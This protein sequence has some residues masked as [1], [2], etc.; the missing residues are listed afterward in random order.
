MVESKRVGRLAQITFS[1]LMHAGC[2]AG[3][4]G[5]SHSFHF[6]KAAA[7]HQCVFRCHWQHVSVSDLHSPRQQR[8]LLQAPQLAAGSHRGVQLPLHC[9]HHPEACQPASLGYTIGLKQIN[10]TSPSMV[11]G[12]CYIFSFVL[13]SKQRCSVKSMSA[14]ELL[15][16]C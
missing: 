15:E 8:L 13:A 3:F 10:F 6:G 16:E 11:T 14:V 5:R 4:W 12:K 9:I 1:G 2:N 7:A